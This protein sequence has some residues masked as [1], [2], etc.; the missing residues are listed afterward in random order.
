MICEPP[1]K[2]LAFSLE[3]T[4]LPFRPLDIFQ[5]K[6]K[7]KVIAVIK[8]KAK[9][10]LMTII[11]IIIVNANK[12]NFKSTNDCTTQLEITVN[13]SSLKNIKCMK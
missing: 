6:I 12:S 13:K 10:K 11:I 3:S 1:L 5:A 7:A 8:Y 9:N 2:R 4:V